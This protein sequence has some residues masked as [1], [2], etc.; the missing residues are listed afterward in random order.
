VIPG[1][2]K[3]SD[4]GV[5]SDLE[6]DFSI[7]RGK[8]KTEESGLSSGASRM[9]PSNAQG[10]N[11]ERNLSRG[12]LIE[13]P[14]E[15]ESL[16]I[17]EKEQKA[18]AESWK[19]GNKNIVFGADESARWEGDP[20]FESFPINPYEISGYSE[21]SEEGKEFALKWIFART[22]HDE[23]GGHRPGES[24]YVDALLYA[25]VRGD[26]DAAE[27]LNELAKRGREKVEQ[28]RQIELKRYEEFKEARKRAI[29]GENLSDMS[30]DD[31]FVVHESSHDTQT[32]ENGDIILRPASDYELLDE[33]GNP[34]LD[35]EGRPFDLYRDTVHFAVNHVVAGHMMRASLKES[36]VIVVPLRSVIEANQGS[37]DTLYTVDTYF[38]PAPGKPLRLPG[39]RVIKNTG[40]ESIGKELSEIMK[41]MG[42]SGRVF[43]SG[44]AY[45]SNGAEAFVTETGLELGVAG[46]TLHSA[47]PGKR[48]ETFR[49][50]QKRNFFID[51]GDLAKMSENAKLRVANDNRFYAIKTKSVRTG[52]SVA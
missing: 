37:L 39:A 20:E 14:A 43:D 33:E 27:K 48:Y 42:G 1:I 17:D 31:L 10:R 47:L 6:I 11:V 3:V 40:Q 2:G 51:S 29:D 45:S 18:I 30:I 38:T 49:K 9:A 22:I 41:E 4:S 25:A 13:S 5:L 34:I 16:D 46:M 44:E 28:E 8:I 35:E 52:R 12:D 32:D 21:T 23:E 24:T 36:N 19:I 7:R 26:Q 15:L 50:H